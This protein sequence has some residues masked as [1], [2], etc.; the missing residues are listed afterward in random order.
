MVG[1][2]FGDDLNMGGIKVKNLTMAVATN[3]TAVTSGVLGIGV[4]TREYSAMLGNLPYGN[5]LDEML[6]QGF[7]SS[8]SYSVWLD[9]LSKPTF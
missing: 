3:A 2:F 1:D 7:I 4:D 5:I 6:D 8:R 9:G